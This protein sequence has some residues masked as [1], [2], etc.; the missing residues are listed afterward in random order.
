MGDKTGTAGIVCMTCTGVGLLMEPFRGAE[1]VEIVVAVVE[2]DDDRE[3]EKLPLVETDLPDWLER[4][5]NLF[6]RLSRDAFLVC[7]GARLGILGAS[8]VF[9]GNFEFGATK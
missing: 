1:I 3:R 9:E 5:A 7:D 2:V 4:R 8:F 6:A